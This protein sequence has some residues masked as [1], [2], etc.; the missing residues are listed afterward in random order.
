MVACAGK[1]WAIANILAIRDQIAI[2]GSND[3]EFEQISAVLSELDEN[4]VS[5]DEAVDKARRVLFAKQD[6]R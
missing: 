1:S 2:Q 3:S 4:R 6:Y 5:P